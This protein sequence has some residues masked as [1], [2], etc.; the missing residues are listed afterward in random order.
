MQEMKSNIAI[1]RELGYG[2]QSA[3]PV[4]PERFIIRR[5][6]IYAAE[7]RQPATIWDAMSNCLADLHHRGIIK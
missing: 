1:R 7:S 2:Q 3:S 5:T 6:G 4:E